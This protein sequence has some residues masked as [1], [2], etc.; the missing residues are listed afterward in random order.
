VY[1]RELDQLLNT[2]RVPKSILL[3][4]ESFFL[5]YY[6]KKIF[7]KLGTKDNILSFYFEEYVYDSAKSHIS[8]PSLFG[9]INILHLRVSKKVSKKELDSLVALCAKN[10]TSYFICEFYGEDRVSKEISRSFSKKNSADFVRFFKPRLNDSLQILIQRSNELSLDIDRFALQHLL[11]LQNEDLALS[12]NELEKLSLLNKKVTQRDIDDN[13]YGMGEIGLDE[14]N[15]KL[16]S[17]EYIVDDIKKVVEIGGNDEI[18]MI[19]S[20]QNFA[21]QLFMFHS[22][23]KVNGRYDVKEILGYPLPPNL[24]QQRANL[25]IKL[26]TKAY[27]DILLHLM[28]SE[29]ALKKLQNIDKSSYLFSSLIKLQTYL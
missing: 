9:D 8:Q 25:S 6:V 19:N 1:Q 2:N 28:Q 18:R 13:V 20:L 11:M 24:V 17:K 4:G 21:L 14:F 27:Q 22:F 29:Y 15:F 10:P 23:I 3:Y 5:D 12:Y 16:F 7:D 26:S